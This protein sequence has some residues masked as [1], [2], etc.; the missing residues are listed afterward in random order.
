MFKKIALLSTLLVLFAV[1]ATACEAIPNIA[2]QFLPTPPPTAAPTATPAPATATAPQAQ[3]NP[4][5]PGRNIQGALRLADLSGGIV[6]DNK[7]GALTL[8]L[9]GRQTERVQTNASTLVVMPGKTNAQIADIRVG[10]RV[11]ADYGN[12]TTNTTA[13]L[14]LDLPA[15]YNMSNVLLAA[16]ISSKGGTINVRTRTGDDKIA[17]TDQTTFVN[18]SGDRPALGAFKDLKQ[19]NV[20]IVIGTDS[21]DAFNAQV[22]VVT[23]R[24]A[25]AILNR[26]RNN[27][28]EPAPTPTPKPGA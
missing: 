8:R 9:A 10:D 5:A 19:G 21:T 6:G 13:A 15:D 24:D 2:S 12:D 7:N 11:I 4:P 18:L 25:R 17:T 14:L 22:I 20:V 16:V 26:G 28:Q 1:S 27:P 3:A 23:D